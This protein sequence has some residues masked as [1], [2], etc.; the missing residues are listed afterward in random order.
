MQGN[1]LQFLRLLFFMAAGALG[2]F[3]LQTVIEILFSSYPL[4][5]CLS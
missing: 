4:N 2:V 1:T 5:D 3:F